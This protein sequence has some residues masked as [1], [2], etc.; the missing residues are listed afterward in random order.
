MTNR[1]VRADGT[2]PPSAEGLDAHQ[3]QIVAWVVQGLSSAAIAERLPEDYSRDQIA[4]WQHK[5]AHAVIIE[6]AR[7]AL[8]GETARMALSIQKPVMAFLFSTM[9]DDE[10]DLSLRLRAA[11]QIQNGYGTERLM[12]AL[13]VQVEANVTTAKADLL[14]RVDQMMERAGRIEADGTGSRL[15]LIEGAVVDGS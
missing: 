8:A 4:R 1:F 13:D 14:A 15:R 2:E 7:G 3:D 9:Q 12:A 5:P 11:A 10:V 6:T